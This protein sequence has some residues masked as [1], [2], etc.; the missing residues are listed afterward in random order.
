MRP[1]TDSVTQGLILLRTTLSYSAANEACDV[2]PSALH[3]SRRYLKRWQIW[4]FD[5]S[6]LA[7][8][9]REAPIAPGAALY[10]CI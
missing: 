10:T 8:T 1:M 5:S 7:G 9:E 4:G 6:Y 3:Q 2:E